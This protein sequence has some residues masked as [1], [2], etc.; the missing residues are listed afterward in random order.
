VVIGGGIT[1]LNAVRCLGSNGV[2]VAVVQVQSHDISHYSRF[3]HEHLKLRNF[4]KQPESIIELLKRQA[5]KWQ[6]WVIFPTGDLALS[7]LSQHRDD[8]LP[9]YRM[10]V[11]HWNITRILLEKNLTYQTADKI[12]IDIPRC[13]G[14]ATRV[15]A[16]GKDIF[17]P[18]VVKPNVSHQ[19]TAHFA[20]KLFV[21]RNRFE[22]LNAVEAVNRKNI[23]AKIFD[24]IPG[25][26]CLFYNYSVYMDMQGEPVAELGMKKLRKDPPFFGICRVGERANVAE[27]RDPTIEILRHIGW[28]GMA[29]AEYKLDQRDG[30][31]RLMEINGRCFMMHGLASRAGVNY[32]YLAWRE[33]GLKE[34]KIGAQP[35]NW[36][37][38][39]IHLLRDLYY[40]IFHHNA[41]GLEL[42]DYVESYRRPRA[43][44]VWSAK[45]PLPFIM[46][47][48]HA[49]RNI[50]RRKSK[51]ILRVLS[52]RL[53]LKKFNDSLHHR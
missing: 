23:P 20:K 35:N 3:A 22:L 21:V 6:N 13:Y 42:S 12:G 48:V 31:F 11:P 19:F 36:W 45:D 40:G 51:R 50:V 28:H 52:H 16:Q 24:F 41:E 38:V 29:N 8:L 32:P 15:N 26:D 37:G 39:W 44:A 33:H 34:K 30:R 25:P 4:A 18:V 46:E 17:F 47:W 43:F 10:T 27:L 1:T 9:Y 2:R 5:Q 7:I 49:T 53:L 14:N